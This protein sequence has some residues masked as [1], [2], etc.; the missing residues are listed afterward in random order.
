MLSRMMN[1]LIPNTSRNRHLGMIAVLLPVLVLSLLT[2]QTIPNGSSH[3]YMIDV[4]ETQIVLN[5]WGTLHATGY[6][7]YVMSGNL[8]TEIMVGLGMSPVIAPAVVSLIW[9]MIALALL[10]RLLVHL[11]E[12]VVVSAVVTLLFGLT[13]TVWVHNSIAE[14]YSFG[15]VILILLFIF[16]LWRD[17]IPYLTTYPARIY[18]LA[19]I[20]GIG[21]AHHRAI[22][23]T[24]PALLYATYPYWRVAGRKLL[25]VVP[26]SLLLGAL[27][28]VQYVYLYLRA[29]AGADWVYGN[30]STWEGFLDQFLGREANRFIGSIDSWD[31]LRANFDLVNSV[32]LTDVFVSGVMVG[33]IGLVIGIF[34]QERVAQ[35]QRPATTFALSGLVAYGFHVTVYSDVLSAL[36]LPITLSLVVGWVFCIDWVLTRKYTQSWELRY[37]FRGSLTV[38]VLLGGVMINDNLRFID[39][40]T[41]DETGLE[42]IE[43]LHDA[44]D[45]S[46]VML[47]WGP[48]YFAASYAQRLDDDLAQITLVDHNADFAGIIASDTTLITPEYT[49]YTQS[50]AWWESR[51]G[52]PVYLHAVAPRLIEIATTP[53]IYDETSESDAIEPIDV[54]VTCTANDTILTV[55]W[56]VHTQPAEDLSVFVHLLDENGTLIAQDDHT[57]PVYGWRP[58]T[59]WQA[60]EVVRDVYRLPP[61][62]DNGMIRYGFYRVLDDGFENVLEFE[63]NACDA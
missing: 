21:I 35:I 6:P 30:P 33:I 55:D 47:A 22:A 44:P 37:I 20:G 38:A 12:R 61:F 9:G 39:D 54:Q 3:Y 11:S 24:I 18:W 2:L 4:G 14:I 63:V 16:A 26:M 62:A 53:D 46:T 49:F 31:A 56:L 28:F 19:V 36:I 45:D 42:T 27:G 1:T 10:Y 23:M 58:L 40:L 8:F 41:R 51:L 17:E 25:V 7:L 15:L 57:H 5:E 32:V 50:Q 13:R 48:R 59:T 34:H 29:D 52:Q 43:S 60:G